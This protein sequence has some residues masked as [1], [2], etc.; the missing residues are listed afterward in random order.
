MNSCN[1]E[2]SEVWS[3]G[4]TILEVYTMDMG[5]PAAFK[6][7]FEN[8]NDFQKRAEKIQTILDEVKVS[9]LT[10][11]RMSCNFCANAL[12]NPYDVII[13]FTY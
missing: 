10:W 2:K 13:L 7:A 5:I 8:I 9:F 3:Y 11:P 1:L 6:T 4:V 12:S